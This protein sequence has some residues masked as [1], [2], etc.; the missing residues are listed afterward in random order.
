MRRPGWRSVGTGL[1]L[2]CGLGGC[3]S[4]LPPPTQSQADLPNITQIQAAIEQTVLAQEHIRVTAYCPTVVPEIKGETFS[5]VAL[6][7]GRARR[8]LTFL[9]T[10]GGGTFV[11]FRQTS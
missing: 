6:F 5:C 3:G 10:E 2:A 4:A 7:S 11:T 8:A 9:V 1:A